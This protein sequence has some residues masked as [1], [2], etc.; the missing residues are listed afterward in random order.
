ML[1]PL[2]EKMC[3]ICMEE[4]E[5]MYSTDCE[6]KMCKEC[7]DDWFDKNKIT[8]P[9]CRTEIKYINNSYEKIRIV[10]HIDESRN[11][12]DIQRTTLFLQHLVSRVKIYRYLMYFSTFSSSIAINYYFSMVRTASEYLD[13][14][15]N[16]NKSYSELQDHI[17]QLHG[18]PTNDK[19]IDLRIWND[20]VSH[21]C[22]IPEKYLTMCLNE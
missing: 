1:D 20:D 18:T 13:D 11:E 16:C 2:D 8:C 15:N 21:I 6:H 10:S 12:E 19:M 3:P 5:D 22:Y 17:N 14:Y 9:L 4:K 7:F